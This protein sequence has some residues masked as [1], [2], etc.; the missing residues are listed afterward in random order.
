R[1]R[2]RGGSGAWRRAGDALL[3]A[4]LDLAHRTRNLIRCARSALRIPRSALDF[5]HDRAAATLPAASHGRPRQAVHRGK[6]GRRLP[7]AGPQGR[8]HAAEDPRPARADRRRERQTGPQGAA[9]DLPG[10]ADARPGPRPPA[11]RRPPPP[12]PPP[13]PPPPPRRPPPPPP[14]PP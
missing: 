11:P 14:P 3:A 9:A 5:L 2:P 6:G 10:A 13:P 12:R 4:R 1:R 8:G 7:V